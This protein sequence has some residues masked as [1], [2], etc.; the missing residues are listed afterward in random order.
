MIDRRLISNI[1]WL[2]VVL[3]LLNSLLGVLVIYSSSHY[4]PG[5]YYLRQLV[6]IGLGLV[7]LFVLLTIDYQTLLTFS[8]YFYGAAV[9]VL[10]GMLVFGQFIKKGSW[11][12][13]KFIQI[14]PSELAKIALVLVLA[15][16]FAEYKRSY[17]TRGAV[18]ASSGLVAVPFLLVAGQPDLGTAVS[19]LPLLLA[20][21]LL[22][23]L[24]PKSVVWVLILAILAGVAGWNFYLKDYQKERLAT[25]IFPDKDPRGAGYHILQS[26]IAIG[27]GGLLGKGFKRGSQSQLRFLPAR[28]TDFIFSVI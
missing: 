12:T 9:C 6:F 24:K 3:V 11:I 19:F 13:L 17:A 2:L 22:A 27:S 8:F 20:A 26:K 14:Q 4:L 21:L 18:L 25:V 5:N 7:V 16:I 10:V 1:D 15:H 28:H 23:G